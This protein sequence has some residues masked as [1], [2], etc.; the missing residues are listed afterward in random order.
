MRFTLCEYTPTHFIRQRNFD[1]TATVQVGDSIIAP[2]PVV[3]ILGLQLDSKL[4]W[5]AHTEA[6]NCKMKVS[7]VRSK[8]LNNVNV[9]HNN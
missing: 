7:N 9:G 8:R 6:V 4:H 3:R 2:S 1:L 5:K